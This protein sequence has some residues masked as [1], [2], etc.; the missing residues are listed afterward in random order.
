MP[1]GGASRSTPATEV[2]TDPGRLR[3]TSTAARSV[4][5]SSIVQE[6]IDKIIAYLKKHLPNL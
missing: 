1:N 2:R 5:S 6:E 4:P 3:D